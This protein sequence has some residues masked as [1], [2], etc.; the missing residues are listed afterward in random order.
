[1]EPT[2][3]ELNLLTI[4]RLC[5]PYE[6]VTIHFDR[7]GKAGFYRVNK[8]QDLIISDEGIKEVK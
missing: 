4:L 8:V 2:Q 6:K 5:K 3:A 1:M 7:E